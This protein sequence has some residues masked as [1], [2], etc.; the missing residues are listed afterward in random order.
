MKRLSSAALVGRLQ[1]NIG[2]LREQRLFQDRLSLAIL[3]PTV[4]LN[5]ITLLI[6]LVKLR[7]AGFD[8]P[9]RYSSLVGFNELGPW[10]SA[11]RIALFGVAVTAVNT[12][13][14]V[15]AFNRSRVTSFFLTVG[16]FVVALFCLIIG[17][18]FAV[19]V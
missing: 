5:F 3:V 6:M 17:T 7:P 16:A 4:I 15:V 13:L 2:S 11:Y 19:I 10:Y 18:A 12:A 14:G 1:T 9:V 8:V